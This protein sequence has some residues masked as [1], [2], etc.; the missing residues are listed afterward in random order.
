MRQVAGISNLIR[1]GSK[2]V[3]TPT[4]TLKVILL[5]TWTPLDC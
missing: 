3:S 1:L 5:V 2:V 4:H